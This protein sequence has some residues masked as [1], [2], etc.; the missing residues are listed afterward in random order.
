MQH[1]FSRPI[2]DHVYLTHATNVRKRAPF[3]NPDGREVEIPE[4][5]SMRTIE[6]IDREA[7]EAIVRDDISR[8]VELV[9][10]YRALGEPAAEIPELRLRGIIAAY[11]NEREAAIEYYERGIALAKEMGA[12]V[13]A[14]LT[15]TNLGH[16]YTRSGHSQDALRIYSEGLSIAEEHGYARGIAN[17]SGSVGMTLAA[18][19]DVDEA[20]PFLKRSMELNEK[21]HDVIGIAASTG[22]LAI[23]YARMGDFPEAFKHFERSKAAYLD[24]GDETGAANITGNLGVLYLEAGSYANAIAAFQEALDVM[25]AKEWVQAA[26]RMRAAI[27]TA[28]MGLEDYQKAEPMLQSILEDLRATNNRGMEADMTA[29]LGELYAR[30]GEFDRAREQYQRAIEIRTEVDDVQAK[31][32]D[33]VNRGRMEM[34]SGDLEAARATAEI[35][36]SM[37]VVL[38]KD[39]VHRDG[40]FADLAQAEGDLELTDTLLKGALASLEDSEYRAERVELLRQLRDLARASGDFDGYVTYNEQMTAMNEEIRGKEAAVKIAMQGAQRE[41]AKERLQRERERAILYSAL[42]QHIADRIVRGEDV[43]GDH[44]ENAAVLFLDVVGFTTHSSV[45]QPHE[46]TALLARIFDRFDAICND[47]GVTKV[48][49]IGDS[50]MA[51]AFASEEGLSAEGP[52]AEQRAASVA[53]EMH[54]AEFYWPSA[55]ADSNSNRVQFRVGLHSG[56]VVAGVIGKERLQY[57]VWGDTVNT[58]SRMESSGEAGKIQVSSAFYEQLNSRAPSNCRTVER[59]IVNIK[60]KGPMTTY[61]LEPA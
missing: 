24:A 29:N 6:E 15:L 7:Q 8:M 20:L 12:H 42:P 19:N 47:H 56:P 48:K 21:L 16:V 4:I 59:G 36:R 60:G 32:G 22:N 45:M 54:Q 53:L 51:V 17:A 26:P 41:V 28:Y 27:A 35:V 52:E 10:E 9:E 23:L 58:A 57:D 5:V 44:H 11:R 39:Q 31:A 37:S 46:T 49:T 14:V 43:S 1:F 40:F 33:L 25:V 55:T 30:R 3:T 2:P 34:R 38:L 18:R 61:W 50:Y 13:E